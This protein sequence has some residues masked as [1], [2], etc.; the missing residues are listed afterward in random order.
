M[1]KLFLGEGSG[2][3]QAREDQVR[4]VVHESE[5]EPFQ[6]A[7][8]FSHFGQIIQSTGHIFSEDEFE[9]EDDPIPATVDDL[10]SQREELEN[11]WYHY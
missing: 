4:R 8:N 6:E 1:T 2:E 7:A 3:D 5:Q 10:M 9:A 11:F